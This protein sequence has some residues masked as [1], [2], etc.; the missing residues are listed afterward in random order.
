MEMLCCFC[1]KNEDEAPLI[2]IA[3][4]ILLIGHKHYEFSHIFHE[5]FGVS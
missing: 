2:E 5:L 3:T 1:G 4:N